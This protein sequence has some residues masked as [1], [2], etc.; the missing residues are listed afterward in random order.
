[1]ALLAKNVSAKDKLFLDLQ[2]QH[3]SGYIAWNFQVNIDL[4]SAID[5]KYQVV[6]Q[7]FSLLVTELLN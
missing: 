5:F 7:V 3:S 6:V 2:P 4:S 1:M